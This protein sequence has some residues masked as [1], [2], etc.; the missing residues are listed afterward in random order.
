MRISD[1]LV[2]NSA[3]DASE[4]RHAVCAAAPRRLRRFAGGRRFASSVLLLALAASLSAACSPV[5]SDGT[6]PR[7]GVHA[8]R[9]A[10]RL[11]VVH[12]MLFEYGDNPVEKK[13]V[14][15]PEGEYVFEGEDDIFLYFRSPEPLEYR[16]HHKEGYAE[17]FFQM[18]GLALASKDAWDEVEYPTCTYTDGED[19]RSK[20]LTCPLDSTFVIQKRGGDWESD[21][22]A[23]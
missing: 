4:A 1:R 14:R 6:I 9:A 19:Q 2:K 18:G 3:D 21:F 20:R 23:E 8:P 10:H 13:T 11:T 17:A 12:E 7:S 15:L 5:S 22:D 16:V